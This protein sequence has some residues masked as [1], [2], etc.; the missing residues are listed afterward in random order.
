MILVSLGA[1][2]PSSEHGPPQATLEAALAAIEAAGVAVSTRS[3][4]YRSRPVPPSAQPWFVNAVAALATALEPVPLMAFLHE[5]ERRFGRRRGRR[6][7]ARVIDLDLLAYHELIL[8]PSKGSGGL[9]LPHPR[10][11]ERAFVL[12]PLAE[13]TPDWRHPE[14]GLGV[15]ELIRGL[16]PDQIA[17]PLEQSF[18]IPE[19]R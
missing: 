14:S 13:V 8:R 6:W 9:V 12:R 15:A 2:L 10:L 7:E 18:A 11:H 16:S 17:E 1:N 3:R 4:W 19:Q 5:V